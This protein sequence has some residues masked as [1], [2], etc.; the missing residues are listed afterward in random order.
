MD[1]QKVDMFIMINGD[2]LP[3]AKTPF[4]R[5]KLL[6]LDDD[7][8]ASLSTLQLKKPIIV[9]V[10]SILLGSFGAD[11]FYLGQTGL[12]LPAGESRLHPPHGAL[13][14][15]AAGAARLDQQHL[16]EM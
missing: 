1:T 13:L 8:W 9:L 10:I 15:P 4:V 7:K 11:R 14:H 3:E 6:A 5:E 16:Q 12:G 2:N